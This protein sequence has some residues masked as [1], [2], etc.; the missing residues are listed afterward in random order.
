M[1]GF[2]E[3]DV[4]YLV[5]SI[6]KMLIGQPNIQDG[7]NLLDDGSK[8]VEEFHYSAPFCND[9]SSDFELTHFYLVRVLG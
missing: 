3:K 5:A 9:S 8:V 6:C 7:L 2:V 1:A 4:D